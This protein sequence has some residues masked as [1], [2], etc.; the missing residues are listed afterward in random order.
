MTE[1]RVCE[2]FKSIQGEST[3]A[4]LPCAF[5]RLTGCPLDCRWCDTAYAKTEGRAMTLEAV[6][7]GV[8]ALGVNLVEVTGGE[9]LAQDGCPALLAAL[10]DAGYEVLL[11]TNGAEDIS[12]VDH[13]VRVI[14]DIKC[15]G[16]GMDG[17]MRWANLEALPPGT[18]IKFV[19]A[20]R[21]DYEYA[22]QVIARHGLAERAEILLSVVHGQLE[23]KR[24]V[25]WMLTDGLR[26]RFQLQ[27]HKFIWP[28]E[29]RGV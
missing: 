22:R 20:D 10:C 2:I 5:V 25:E 18:Q 3:Y 13:R 23:P 15:P 9:P 24:V 12:V 7:A 16:S 14:M 6:L 21:A 8:A 26:T 17:A 27:M 1:L 11:E 19:L 4:G 29:A 28:P